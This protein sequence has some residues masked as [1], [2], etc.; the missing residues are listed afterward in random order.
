MIKHAKYFVAVILSAI[1]AVSFS[2]CA[3]HAPVEPPAD[4]DIE[5]GVDDDVDTGKDDG[6]VK[7]ELNKF[8]GATIDLCGSSLREYLSL[9]NADE[10]AEF[11]YARNFPD[12][13]EQSPVFSWS[14]D[15]S[16]SY[17]VYFSDDPAF[18][19][20]VSFV[21][22]N[23]YVD[24]IGFFI[25]GETYYWKVSG[26]SG[27]SEIDSFSALDAPIR[28]IEAEG[29]HNIRDLGGWRT[30]DGYQVKYG[31]LYRGGQLNGYA[32]MEAMTDNGKYVFDEVL[33]IKSELDL[34]TP[35]KDDGGQASCWWNS[36]AGYKKVP[37]SQYG[38]IIPHF[39]GNA[40]GVASYVSS[41]LPAIKEIFTYLSDI[42]NYPIYIH[43]NAG[44]DRTGTLAFLIGGLLGVSYEDL[45]R[46][47]ETTSFTYYGARWRSDIRNGKFTS[48]G[49]MRDDRE[50]FIGWGQMYSLFMKYY[51]GDAGTLS[52]A[53]ENYLVNTCKVDVQCIEQIKDIMLQ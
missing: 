33:G 20:S 41:S 5:I 13:D 15:G 43:C 10:Q 23:E 18:E 34:R 46:D 36:A 48:T 25:P 29:S 52:Y 26:D 11:L 35:G 51:A 3:K 49:V 9:E 8:D 53:I 4:D 21:S 14:D 47:F 16:E 39:G 32:G 2:A 42:N 28:I 40:N 50:N 6:I 24:D 30:L 38:C 45:T 44:S 7:I 27:F 17:T 19:N 31:L 37:L 12:Q 1:I 22:A